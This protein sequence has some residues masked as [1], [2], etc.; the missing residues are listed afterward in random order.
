MIRV[1]GGIHR[2]QRIYVP[3][4]PDVRPTTGR[5]REAVFN[6]LGGQLSGA[7][8]LDLFA[9]SGLLGLEALSR[10]A[11]FAVFVDSNP[12]ACAIIRQN[13]DRLRCTHQTAVIQGALPQTAT[14]T[15]L[16]TLLQQKY[17]QSDK[18]LGLI[19]LDPPYGRGFVPEVLSNIG[20]FIFVNPGTLAVAEHEAGASLKDC[21]SWEPL[22]YRR[23]GDTRISIFSMI[24][25]K[26]TT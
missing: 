23:Y 6:I 10:G 13:C 8:V 20:K 15:K 5:V 11:E 25:G 18:R 16:Q 17:Q 19:F 22:Q 12:S 26:D 14:L 24:G 9:G 1:S 4:D 21:T 7:W 3:D 2:G